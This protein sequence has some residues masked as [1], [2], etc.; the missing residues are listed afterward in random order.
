MIG[1]FRRYVT[2]RLLNA[3]VVVSLGFLRFAADFCMKK[4]DWLE[5]MYLYVSYSFEKV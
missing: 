1:H 2:E 3:K 4:C 5:K